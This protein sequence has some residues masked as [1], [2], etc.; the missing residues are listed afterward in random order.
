MVDGSIISPKAT[1]RSETFLRP[2]G[3][4]GRFI[5]A[6]ALDFFSPGM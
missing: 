1:K 2:S 6:P 4:A 5:F 3:D